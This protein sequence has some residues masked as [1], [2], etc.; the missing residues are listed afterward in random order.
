M[1]V[2]VVVSVCVCNNTSYNKG[3]RHPVLSTAWWGDANTAVT[4]GRGKGILQTNRAA[5]HPFVLHVVVSCKH[6]SNCWKGKGHST[7]KQG[8]TAS[9][10]TPCGGKL[11]TL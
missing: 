10:C 7:N 4:A 9:L 6:C 3:A 8:S 5:Q 1:V 2:V 11:Q